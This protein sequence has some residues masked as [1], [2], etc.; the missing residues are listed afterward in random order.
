MSDPEYKGPGPAY[1]DGA[2]YLGTVSGGF[3]RPEDISEGERQMA[4]SAHVCVECKYFEH[5]QGQEEIRVSKFL[6]QLTR[7]HGWKLRHLASPV[8]QIGIC[9]AH[10]AGTPGESRTLT[11]AMAKSCD[12]FVPANGLV[13]SARRKADR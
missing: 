13:R 12:Q 7:E 4:L 2:R 6:P 9:G 1:D 5:R 11:S 8:N 3:I 10:S